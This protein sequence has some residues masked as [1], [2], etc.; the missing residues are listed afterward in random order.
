MNRCMSA[1][2]RAAR[3][4]ARA[5]SPR[6]P[7]ASPLRDVPD[8]RVLER[9]ASRSSSSAPRTA[10]NPSARSVSNTSSAACEIG[11]GVGDHRAEPRAARGSGSST[12]VTSARHRQAAEVAAPGDAQPVERRRRD[13]RERVGGSRRRDSGSRASWPASAPSSSAAS[14]TVR[15]IGPTTASEPHASDRSSAAG[16]AAGRRAQ[17]DDVAE[18]GRVADARRRGRTRRRAA[19]SPR[20]PPRRR[21]RCCRRTSASRSYGLRV[22]PKTGLNVCEPAPNSGVFV[23]PMMIA[24]ARRSALD[25]QAVGRRDVV[26][27]QRRAVGRPHP[28]R[29]LEVLDRDR[30]PVQRAERVAAG[31]RPVGV[32]GRCAG[33]A[34]VERDDRVDVRVDLGDP[35]QVGLHRL[36]GRDRAGRDRRGELARAHTISPS[37][38]VSST[39][40]TGS[41][42]GSTSAGSAAS[43]VMSARSPG[44]S[45]P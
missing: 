10:A 8:D 38:T 44:R 45:R 41:S 6:R 35:R 5:R 15:A 40:S 39:G 11:L 27:E 29:V 33:A 28:G 9:R 4:R 26:G 36:G 21:R 1:V 24:P 31:D 14:S 2:E 43:A 19:A 12:A 23:L 20:R 37:T 22:A 3:R 34:F 42:S 32:G 13:A 17:P 18:R 25:E 7:S 16:I 30:Q